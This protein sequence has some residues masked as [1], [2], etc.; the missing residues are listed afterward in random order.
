M[1]NLSFNKLF[2]QE[3]GGE[4]FGVTPGIKID[5]KNPSTFCSN[6]G[7]RT[8]LMDPCLQISESNFFMYN[9]IQDVQKPVV[10]G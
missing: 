2:P 8:I 3:Q 9:L 7:Y 6:I 4:L 5:S 1:Q 10:I